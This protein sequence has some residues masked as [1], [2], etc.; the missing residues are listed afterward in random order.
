MP[1]PAYHSSPQFV[2][3]FPTV[4]EAEPQRGQ[5]ASLVITLHT[6]AVWSSVH[7]DLFNFSSPPNEAG[8]IISQLYKETK[9]LRRQEFC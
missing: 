5:A 1:Y 7:N 2:T 3:P 4:E 8:I 9:V 6:H